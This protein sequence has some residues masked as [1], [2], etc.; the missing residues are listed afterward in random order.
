M[1][2]IK[3]IRIGVSPQYF[4]VDAC[5][6]VDAALAAAVDRDESTV[7]AS[8]SL[9][10]WDQIYHYANAGISRIYIS[11]ICIAESF[12]AIAKKFFCENL[13][14]ADEKKIAEAK[15]R[16]WISMDHT[17]L[18]QAGRKVPVHDLSTNR[19]I[20]ISSDRFLEIAMR[21]KLQGLSVPDLIVAATAKYLQDF[22]DLPSASLHVVT[23]DKKLARLI[24]LC[25][26]FSAPIEP[27]IHRV[28][29][30]IVLCTR[31]SARDRPPRRTD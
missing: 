25:P 13:I 2:R 9:E 1:S 17:L 19:D 20:I 14:T 30:I 28:E 10:W 16:G 3:K 27:A 21:N 5:V 11:D 22:Y 6:L 7:Q 12:K 26:E 4:V 31:I 29:D 24:R 15:L 8:R 18:K 23:N